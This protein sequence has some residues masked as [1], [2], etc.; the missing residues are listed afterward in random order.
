MEIYAAMH[1]MNAGYQSLQFISYIQAKTNN[2]RM[3]KLR[4]LRTNNHLSVTL[5][6][7]RLSGQVTL[8]REKFFA[9]MNATWFALDFG[10]DPLHG[11]NVAQPSTSDQNQTAT[12]TA[13][14][15]RMVNHCLMANDPVVKV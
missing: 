12:T 1:A 14:A 3:L 11:A 7:V 15:S 8:T 5:Y 2:Q 10:A 4:D 6:S 9:E 13:T